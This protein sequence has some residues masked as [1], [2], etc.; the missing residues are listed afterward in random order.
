VSSKSQEEIHELS[1]QVCNLKEVKEITDLKVGMELE[2]IDE[3]GLT[4]EHLVDVG[5]HQDGLVHICNSLT[6]C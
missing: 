2:G 5:V 4:L 6:V 3:C 1:F